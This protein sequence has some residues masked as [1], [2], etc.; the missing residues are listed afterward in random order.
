VFSLATINDNYLHL[1][2][3]LCIHGPAIRVIKVK[4]A[5]NHLHCSFATQETISSPFVEKRRDSLTANNC[6]STPASSRRE[7]AYL[8]TNL[9]IINHMESVVIFFSA[10]PEQ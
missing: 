7:R 2:A 5:S 10:A 9:P 1:G 3:R 4:A 8:Y 6:D